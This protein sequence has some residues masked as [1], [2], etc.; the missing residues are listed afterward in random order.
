MWS[1]DEAMGV[2]IKH[3]LRTQSTIES[4]EMTFKRLRVCLSDP[5]NLNRISKKHRAYQE[6]ICGYGFGITVNPNEIHRKPTKSLR[7][8]E[9]QTH[10]SA[11]TKK[12][13]NNTQ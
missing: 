2:T 3:L 11:W 9:Q 4:Y 8:L 1:I 6:G 12:D 10:C 5:L 7:A 13:R